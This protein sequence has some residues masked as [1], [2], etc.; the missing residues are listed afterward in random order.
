MYK[1]RD[2]YVFPTINCDVSRVWWSRVYS[3]MVVTCIFPMVVTCLSPSS[4]SNRVIHENTSMGLCLIYHTTLYVKLLYLYQK[5]YNSCKYLQMLLSTAEDLLGSTCRDSCDGESAFFP[6][7]LNR[8]WSD[9][10]SFRFESMI[11]IL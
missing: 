4:L 7:C 5:Q 6:E 8:T 2:K 9:A 11:K 1:T 10:I 3:P